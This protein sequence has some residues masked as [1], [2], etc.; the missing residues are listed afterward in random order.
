MFDQKVRVDGVHAGHVDEAAPADV[1]ARAVVLDVH[2]AEVSGLPVVELEQVHA[3]QEHGDQHGAADVPAKHLVL[4]VGVADDAHL[5]VHEAEAAVGKLLDVEAEDARVQLGTPEEV[6]DHTSVGAGVLRG[7]KSQAFD[8]QH[9]TKAQR[10]DIQRGQ[11]VAHLVVHFGGAN[12]SVVCKHE[13]SHNGN[14]VALNSVS[15]VHR[16]VSRRGG[17]GLE[18]LA[19]YEPHQKELKCHEGENHFPRG[20]VERG[21][22]DIN[23]EIDNALLE[24][25][26]G[27]GS[28][29]STI[30]L[31]SQDEW[32][33]KDLGK[34][35]QHDRSKLTVCK[36][37]PTSP[38]FL[39]L[40]RRHRRECNDTLPEKSANRPQT[41]P[42]GSDGQQKRTISRP[43][44]KSVRNSVVFVLPPHNR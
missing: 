39:I 32:D 20:R 30:I 1:I 40:F 27:D 21:R 26:L 43:I 5:P 36:E 17:R 14:K 23:K 2:G 33:A 31:A 34:N 28:D 24:S 16:D 29:R 25:S 12:D 22:P 8:R 13:G 35:N 6:D 4:L 11:N 37:T 10:K 18:N 38:R 15:I 41:A 9:G 19:R 44:F 42:S 7:G 3:L